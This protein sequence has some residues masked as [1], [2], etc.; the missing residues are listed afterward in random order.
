[1]K[2]NE[3]DMVVLKQDL[4]QEG[5]KQG[6]VGAVVLV[7]DGGAGYEVEFTTFKGQT[8]S[9]V[10]VE[11]DAIRPVGETDVIHTRVSVAAVA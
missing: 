3:L 7:Y 2:L 6:D 8:L 11:P 9:V 1:V 4:P 10:T 5:L